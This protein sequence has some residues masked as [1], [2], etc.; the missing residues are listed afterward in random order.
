MLSEKGHQVTVFVNDKTIH[1]IVIEKRP[2]ARIIRFNP[3]STNTDAFLGN[4]TH[5]S[6]E[7]SMILKKI[8]EQEGKPDIIESQDYNGIGYF[9][10]QHKACLYD[11]CKGIPIV[12]TIHSPS[13]LYMEYNEVPLYERPN[14]WIGEMERFCIQ[15]ADLVISPSQYLIDELEQRFKMNTANLHVVPNPYHFDPAESRFSLNKHCL[16]NELTFYGKLSPQ[17]GTFRILE[18]FKDLWDKGFNLPFTMIGG[19]EIV[20]SP[21]GKTMGTIIKKEYD[22]YIKKGFLKLKD[23]IP[24]DER[25]AFL[26]G[27]I[28]FIIPSIV[29]NLPYAV[30]ELMSLGK[31]LIV[32]KQGGQAEVISNEKDGFIFDYHKTADFETVLNRVLQLTK[33]ERLKIAEQAIKKIE[34]HYSYEII[35]SKKIE[36]L[37]CLKADNK[38]MNQFPFIRNLPLKTTFRNDLDNSLL[39]VVIPY[40]NLGEYLDESVDSIF[41]ATYK[42]VEVIII[43]DGSTDAVSINKLKKYRNNNSV[44]VIDKQNTGLADSRNTG[45]EMARGS[46]IAFLDADDTV[47]PEYYEK[48]IAIL[49]QY[50][51]VHFV[52][53]WT[54][55]FGNSKNVWPT[56]NP[57]PPLLLVHNLINSSALV[58]KT[59]AF[60][61]GGKNDKNFKI[62]LEDY[63][64]VISMKSNGLNGVVIPEILFN[65]RVRSHSMIKNVNREVR[66]MYYNNIEQKHHALFSQFRKDIDNLIR[67]H[68]PLSIDNPTL[69]N[70]PFQHIPFLGK[71]VRKTIHVVKAK[72]NL[73]RFVLWL[74]RLPPQ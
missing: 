61:Q 34:K 36:L 49:Q 7:F 65:Y 42:N 40:F 28:L 14:F 41:K 26:S 1:S 73:R 12:I 4:I 37:E 46:F 25:R 10:L 6:Y 60:L 24:P 35:Y 38:V 8:I 22:D 58:Y 2:E 68:K 18:R 52:G 31:I 55:Y 33:E 45:A 20:F 50:E 27:S 21:S 69:D 71:I 67:Y 32:S 15:A 39:S 56:F 74:K 23:K 53:A 3:N 5:L 64:S 63:E 70:Y 62:G 59:Q 48:A 30:L 72:P 44:H 9:L 29:D 43:N 66:E 51:N 16:N 17:K 19:Q 47:T 54:K 11:W 57:E 13:F